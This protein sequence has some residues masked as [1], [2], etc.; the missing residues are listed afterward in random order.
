M[1][2]EILQT[3]ID[4]LLYLPITDKEN[5]MKELELLNNKYGLPVNKVNYN[6]STFKLLS[7]AEKTN[8]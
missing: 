3:V 7:D 5:Y 2:K 1:N 8:S 4:R 6:T